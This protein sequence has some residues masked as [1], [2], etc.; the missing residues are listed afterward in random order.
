MIVTRPASERG[1]TRTSWLDSKHTFSFNRYHDPSFMGFRSLR[2][3]N[4]DE[5]APG[6]RFGKHPHDNMEIITYVL[7]GSVS[8]EDS[9]GAKGVIRPGDAQRMSAGTGIW[10]SEANGSL[11]DPVHFLQIWIEPGEAGLEPGYEQKTFPE[12]ERRNRLRLIAA[13]DGRLGA[14]TIHQDAD[15]YA[16]LLDPQATVS[17]DLEA[18]RSAWLQVAKGEVTL[19]G[20]ALGAGDGAAIRDETRLDITADAPSEVLLFDLA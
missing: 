18:G 7:D 14:V 4:D 10:H 20:V 6:G 1:Q 15:L 12:S 2:V 3:I 16:S 11:Q 5:V 9:T 13:P 17:H 19:N 8:H